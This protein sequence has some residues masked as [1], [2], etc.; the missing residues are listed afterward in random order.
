M[1]F[2]IGGKSNAFKNYIT[3]ISR[4][5]HRI[6]QQNSFLQ[7]SRFPSVSK[8]GL[9][10]LKLNQGCLLNHK[11]NLFKNENFKKEVIS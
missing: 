6:I 8:L 4:Y 10:Q 3:S 2:I 11:L 9:M 1:N 7:P 5:D